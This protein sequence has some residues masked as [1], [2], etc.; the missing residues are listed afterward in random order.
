MGPINTSM[1]TYTSIP[2]ITIICMITPMT[3]TCMVS[4]TAAVVTTWKM[5]KRGRAM[6]TRQN[7]A[8]KL[9]PA[10]GLSI[11]TKISSNYGID[12]CRVLPGPLL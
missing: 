3:S 10:I 6:P 2:M 4:T 9:R 8:E 11:T 5:R 1:C 7:S 12:I